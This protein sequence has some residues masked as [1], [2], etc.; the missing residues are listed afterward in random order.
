M[1]TILPAWTNRMFSTSVQNT[2]L[3]HKWFTSR[4]GGNAKG[5]GPSSPGWSSRRM[6]VAVRV[7]TRRRPAQPGSV[8]KWPAPRPVRVLPLSASAAWPRSPVPQLQPAHNHPDRFDRC[9]PSESVAGSGLWR[10][11]HL[12]QLPPLAPAGFVQNVSP[13]HAARRAQ[14]PVASGQSHRL[15]W[16]H[17][18]CYRPLL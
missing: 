9:R 2:V 14:G 13:A 15:K 18:A 12:P 8:S 10:R 1:H 17:S 11:L 7:M 16:V 5:H 6:P 4:R 3:S